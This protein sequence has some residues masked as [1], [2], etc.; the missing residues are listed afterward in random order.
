[1]P[2]KTTFTA[3]KRHNGSKELQFNISFPISL[4]TMASFNS[5]NQL[6]TRLARV[7]L[8]DGW[9]EH[10]G[11]SPHNSIILS[12]FINKLLYII[13]INQALEWSITCNGYDISGSETFKCCSSQFTNIQ[14]LYDILHIIDNGYPCCG[15]EITQFKDVITD[16]EHHQI[17]VTIG[18]NLKSI[19]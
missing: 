1:M 10:H 9:L 16:E 11:T 2:R 14:Y 12:K 4:F 13:N 7:S 15:N 3:K 18:K 17:N 5:I 8:P 19:N 6:Q